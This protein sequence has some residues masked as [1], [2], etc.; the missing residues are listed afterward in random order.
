MRH[1]LVLPGARPCRCR[2]LRCRRVADPFVPLFPAAA[3]LSLGLRCAAHPCH[4]LAHSPGRMRSSSRRQR[5]RR[6][7]RTRVSIAARCRSCLARSRQRAHQ[8][9]GGAC[10]GT[11]CSVTRL[12]KPAGR[13]RTVL[14]TNPVRLCSARF[15]RRTDCSP[16]AASHSNRALASRCRIRSRTLP[17]P[18]AQATSP[19]CRRA[20]R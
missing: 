15:D 6:Q 1:L 18:C 2:R 12:R 9:S 13:L 3:R 11:Q 14:R 10:A 16:S 19:C 5:G 17:L 4:S 7:D 20:P 8:R